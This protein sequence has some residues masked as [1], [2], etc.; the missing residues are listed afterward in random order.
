VYR[1]TA[2]NRSTISSID[3][4]QVRSAS[5]ATSGWRRAKS[6]IA[7]PAGVARPGDVPVEDRLVHGTELFDRRAEERGAAGDQAVEVG[8]ER[9]DSRQGPV[10]GDQLLAARRRLEGEVA[11]VRVPLPQDPRQRVEERA[12]LLPVV[13]QPQHALRRVPGPE[14]AQERVLAQRGDAR[15]EGRGVR[16]AAPLRACLHAQVR[17]GLTYGVPATLDG[18]A[19]VLADGPAPAR[20]LELA[21]AADALRERLGVR[22][23]EHERRQR[24]LWLA[25]AERTTDARGRA[26]AAARGG[27]WTPEQAAARALRWTDAVGPAPD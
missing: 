18:L 9:Q 5:A 7:P 22:A 25:P 2:P 15:D 19:G 27:A 1:C 3:R 14:A 17:M 23:A 26:A 12:Q 4:A 16:G 11:P 21:A 24:T 10:E 20:A 13:P 6:A 8:A